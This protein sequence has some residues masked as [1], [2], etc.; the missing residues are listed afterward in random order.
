MEKE[1]SLREIINE[2][3]LFFINYRRIII[4]TT[5]TGFLVVVLFQ[6]FRPA[7]YNTKAIVTSGI[8]VFERADYDEFLDQS[9]AIDLINLLQLDIRNEDY[10]ILS[11]KMNIAIDHASSI[12]SIIA[13]VILIKDKDEKE[14]ASSKFSIDLTLSNNSSISSIEQGL[15]F[16]FRNNNYFINYY[17]QFLSTTQNE[18]N[19]IDKEVVSLRKLRQSENST[20]DVSSLNVNSRKSKYSV[21][22]Q[23]L[24]L[25]NLRSKNTTDLTLLQPLLFVAPFTKTEN[26]QSEVLIIGSIS[27]GI[28]FL[29]G[30]FIAVFRNVYV[31]SKKL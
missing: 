1:L 2:V 4:T 28:S 14:I 25:I 23:I 13:K 29:L 26:P 20:I 30:I 6:K 22:N 8:S 15:L 31:S 11:D 24:E 3:I 18:I 27:A 16:Y 21:N 9:V 17:E 19:A 7:F 12:K 10:S 5:I